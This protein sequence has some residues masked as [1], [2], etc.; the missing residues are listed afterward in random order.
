VISGGGALEIAGEG[1]VVF[2][3]EVDYAVGRGCLVVQCFEVVEATAAH[4]GACG[5]EGG[6][7]GVRAGEPDDLVAGAE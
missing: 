7:G 3:G 1:E 6:G 2:E 5:G 4:L